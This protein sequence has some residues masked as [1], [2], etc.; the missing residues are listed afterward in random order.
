MGLVEKMD[1]GVKILSSF[2]DST[3]VVA[4]WV[5]GSKWHRPR[6]FSYGILET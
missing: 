3:G 6:L 4:S 2:S 1:G 5:R